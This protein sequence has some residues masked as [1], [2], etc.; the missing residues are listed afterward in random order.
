MSANKAKGTRWETEVVRALRDAGFAGADRRALRG[1]ADCGDITG[2]PGLV[3]EARNRKRVEPAAW[4]DEVA[5][6]RDRDGARYGVAWFH[7][8]GKSRAEDGFVL[9]SGEDFLKLLTDAQ[10]IGKKGEAGRG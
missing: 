5:V 1:T 9:M 6:K 2:V 4:I 10:G 8:R 3:I 7:R